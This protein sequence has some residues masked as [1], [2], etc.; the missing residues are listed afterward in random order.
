MSSDWA[1]GVAVAEASAGHG[2][3]TRERLYGLW[4]EDVAREGKAK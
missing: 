4:E 2:G 1:V 3:M